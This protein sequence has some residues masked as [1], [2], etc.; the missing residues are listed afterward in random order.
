MH[1]SQ[2]TALLALWFSAVAAGKPNGVVITANP[3]RR[4][5]IPTAPGQIGIDPV[6]SDLGPLSQ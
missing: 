6:L 4:A 5:I 3:V 2:T 1:I